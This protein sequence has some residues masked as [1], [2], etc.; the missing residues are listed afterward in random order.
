MWN[1]TSGYV[2]CHTCNYISKHATSFGAGVAA[3]S[4]ESSP[5]A[6]VGRGEQPSP[7]ADVGS[8][9]P[10]P[11]ADVGSGEPSPGADVGSDKKTSRICV[12]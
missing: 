3:V 4:R 5:S 2:A 8:G 7:G 11:G 9:E 10:S 6:D 1:V 12:A